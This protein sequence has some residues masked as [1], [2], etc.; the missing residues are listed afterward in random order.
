[1]RRMEHVGDCLRT[2]LRGASLEKRVAEWSLILEWPEI[3]GPEIAAHSQAQDL[4]DGVLWVA[5]PSSNWRQHILFLKPQILGALR[6]K[7]PEIPVR[8]IR[9]LSRHATPRPPEGRG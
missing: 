2:F 6:K 3:V 8:E 4:R 9:C 5:V 7:H 1:M